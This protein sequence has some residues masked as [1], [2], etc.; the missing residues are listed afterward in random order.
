MSTRAE[1][2]RESLLQALYRLERGRG[3]IVKD[4]KLSIAAVA[5][6]AGVSSALIHNRYP[7]VADQINVAKNKGYRVQRD[8]KVNELKRQKDMNRELRAEIA[9]LY[10]KLAKSASVIAALTAENDRL[11]AIVSSE[12]TIVLPQNRG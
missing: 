6:E 7:D 1:H 5:R 9:E 8:A 2:T 12:N 11:A 4:G 3:R 10:A